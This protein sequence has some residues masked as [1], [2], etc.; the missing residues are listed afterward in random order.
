MAEAMKSLTDLLREPNYALLG[1]GSSVSLNYRISR[2]SLHSRLTRLLSDDSTKW[3][4]C[5]GVYPDICGK[6]YSGWIFR[7][8]HLIFTPKLIGYRQEP[9]RAVGKMY[10]W[11]AQLQKLVENELFK[12]RMV[13]RSQN[14]LLD[15]ESC[16]NPRDN[17]VFLVAE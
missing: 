13:M 12:W 5:A 14:T 17:E 1:M 11:L 7:L 6:K 4:L 3:L 10:R 15:L 9:T 8:N 16:Q 2:I